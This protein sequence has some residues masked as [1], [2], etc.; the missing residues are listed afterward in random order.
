MTGLIASLSSPRGSDFAL[1]VDLEVPAE[2]T[3]ALVGPNGSGKSTVVSMLAGTRR[4]GDGR[5]QLNDRILFDSANSVAVPAES[6][7]IGVMFQ[8]GLLFPRMTVS[9]NVAFGPRAAGVRRA[10]AGVLARQWLEALDV[11]HLADRPAGQLSGGESQLVAMARAIAV[12]P[13]L[14]ILDEPLSALDVGVRARV[15]RS[16]TEVLAGFEGSAIVI[17]HD[18]TEAFLMADTIVVMEAGRTVQ[19]GSVES[20]KNHPASKYVADL[21]GINFVEGVATRGA[22]DLGTH[23]LI[24][25]DLVA[26]GP[27]VALVHPRAISLH[28]QRPQGSARNVWESSVAHVE[29]VDDIVRVVL[30][31]PLTLTAEV[32][33]EG[34]SAAGVMEGAPVWVSIKATEI[35]LRETGESR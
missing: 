34:A 14:L 23:Q 13:E 29:S 20:L 31:G 24:S 33:P 22:V 26:T 2:T 12:E 27:V 8:D 1:T 10:D 19:S 11:A 30:G 18:P 3:V 6:R 16:M 35:A 32:T 4:P 17:T 15:R 28:G 21:V 7:R 5:I 25:A 9:D